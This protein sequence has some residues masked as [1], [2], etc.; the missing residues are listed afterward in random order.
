[1]PKDY[2]ETLGVDRSATADE[3]KKAYRKKAMQYHPDRNPGDKGA[4]R[5]FKD[6]AEAYSVLTDAEKRRAYDQYGH[7]GVSGAGRGGFEWTGP[8]L[9]D[10]LRMFMEGFGGFGSFGDAFGTERRTRSQRR[11][12]SD[13]KV[14]LEV[15]LEE[16]AT[17]AE[18]KIKI[19]RQEHCPTCKGSGSEP[20]TSERTCPVCQGRGEVRQVAQSLFGQMVNVGTC[21]N[22]GGRG[23]IV[24][25]LCREC[26]GS[27]LVRR[28]K[29]V[30]FS[31]PAG[32]ATGNY[33]TIRGEG[34]A[35]PRGGP[36]GD[37]VVFFTEKEH[38]FFV[39]HGQD[40]LIE[41]R[42]S[43]SQAALGDKIEVPTLNGKASLRVPAGIQ[44][45]KILRM[46]GKGV[47]DLHTGRRGDQLVRIQVW[48]PMKL[49]NKQRELLRELV[50][51]DGS[52]PPQRFGKDFF[53]RAK[54]T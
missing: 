23:R 11:R 6:L 33:L 39:R 51:T 44:S 3:I 10:A 54:E 21:S 25:H 50:A 36:A 2:Y 48:T 30:A 41:A 38:P 40:I 45:G 43:F 4:E 1:M 27:G 37:I 28:H 29:T 32:I 14:R 49:T 42:I 20:G 18:K 34:N 53:R 22:C 16:V 15:T 9:S 46:G 26:G 5:N 35:G 47:P 8:D 19:R 52:G 7:A 12:G 13:L 24:E 17:G 31:I